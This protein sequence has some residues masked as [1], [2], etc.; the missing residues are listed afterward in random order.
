MYS[1]R[2]H[3]LVIYISCDSTMSSNLHT[4]SDVFLFNQKDQ[5]TA[6]VEGG[7]THLV[8]DHLKPHLAHTEPSRSP[9]APSGISTCQI[10]WSACAK[11]VR[12]SVRRGSNL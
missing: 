6:K 4:L 12:T 11:T 5:F 1:A 7:D 9:I 10:I 2:P 3:M 8:S